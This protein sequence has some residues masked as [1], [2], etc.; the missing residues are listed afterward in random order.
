MGDDE[1]ACIGGIWVLVSYGVCVHVTPAPMAGGGIRGPASSGLIIGCNEWRSWTAAA[2]CSYT[3]TA[4]T[5]V[6]VCMTCTCTTT[7]QS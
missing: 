6:Y 4:R 2:N 7:P 1:Y 3:Y 5:H